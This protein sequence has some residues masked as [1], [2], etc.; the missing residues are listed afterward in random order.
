MN[1]LL[2][3]AEAIE[4]FLQLHLKRLPWCPDGKESACNA[5]HLSSILDWEDPLEKEMATHSRILAWRIPWTE[6]LDGLQSMGLQR[7]G[8]DWATNTFT[9]TLK[10]SNVIVW[11]VELIILKWLRWVFEWSISLCYTNLNTKISATFP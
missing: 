7:V 5:G 1:L 6:E 10:N 9:F 3:I 2:K 8:H 11:N 4:L